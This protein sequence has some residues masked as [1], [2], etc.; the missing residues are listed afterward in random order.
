MLYS[1]TCCTIAALSPGSMRLRPELQF[2]KDSES[3]KFDFCNGGGGAGITSERS[4]VDP[5]R[6]NKSFEMTRSAASTKI[7]SMQKMECGARSESINALN[8][9]NRW[10]AVSVVRALM[11]ATIACNVFTFSA[12]WKLVIFFSTAGMSAVNMGERGA[13]SF[14]MKSFTAIS[15]TGA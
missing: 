9:N 1:A 14:S 8:R 6:C 11:L 3:V 13:L 4:G 10:S 2:D 7:F 5:Y 15:N 12:F